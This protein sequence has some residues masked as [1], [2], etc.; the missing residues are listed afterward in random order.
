MNRNPIGK[1][2]VMMLTVA[3]MLSAC[4]G[5]DSGSN[6]Y[7]IHNTE[8]KLDARA[9]G[10]VTY[11]YTA[12]FQGLFEPAFS[13]GEDDTQVL[14]FITEPMFKGGDDLAT[15]PHI[16][17]WQE[18][19]DHTVF[20]FKIKPGIRWHNGE[21]L[22]VEDWKFAIET[23]AHPDY[24]GSRYYSV[25]MVKGIEAYHQGKA[26]EI[27]GIRVLDPYTLR[28]TVTGARVN[29]IDTLWPYPM[30]KEYYAGVDV[31]DMQDSEQVRTRPIGIG[32]F[33]VTDIQPGQR[34]EMKRFDQY[35]QGKAL[36]DGINYTVVDEKTITAQFQNQSLDI[37]SAPR[38]AYQ[39]LSKLDNIRILESPE[40]SYEYIGFKFGHWDKE[41]Q[42][43]VM[44]NPKFSD[45]K[46]RQAMY[47]ALDR[48]GIINQFSYGLGTAIETPVPSASW[49]KVPDS[50]INPY[51]YNPL[52]ARTLLDEAGYSD[53]DG[54]GLRE[55]PQGQKLVI[56]YDSMSGGQSAEAR[57]AA[58]LQD[59]REVGLDVRLNGGALKDMN[60]FYEAV[61]RDDPSIELFN[62]VWGL[63]NDPDPSGLWREQDLWN[64]PRWSSDRNE[65]LI[66]DGVSMRAYD[67]E[68]RKQV[69]YE[70]QQ[71][72][73][74]EVPML[75][76][77]ERKSITPVQK[78]VQGVRVNT[79]GNIIEPQNWWIEEQS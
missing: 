68:Y 66:K 44:D 13:E 43:I 73:N 74:E 16:A 31:K 28:I 12:P 54:D 46:L 32:P 79:F 29:T 15:V 4:S 77:A 41:K 64:Y 63:S 50:A 1:V 78:R 2:I 69:Y 26:S 71:L 36:L 51:E 55:D 76:F 9:G 75:F 67:S 65:A 7:T 3:G 21:E 45:K 34:V 20:T 52:K 8:T 25:E 40:L 6:T 58:I 37:A 24:T 14:E 10:V 53:I 38:D 62:G 30:N 59:W 19:E 22:T 61:E 33:Q 17:T 27:T 60:T 18:S 11:G 47:Y 72:L 39:G 70:W 56:H 5:S 48:Q 42:E 49:A 57:T 23:I 35:H